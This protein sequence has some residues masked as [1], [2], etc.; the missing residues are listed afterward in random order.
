MAQHG[1]SWK[2]KTLEISYYKLARS[3]MPEAGFLR[4]FKRRGAK[5]KDKTQLNPKATNEMIILILSSA[6]CS[7]K[8]SSRSIT[9]HHYFVSFFSSSSEPISFI[10]FL[11]SL[12][13]LPKALPISGSLVAPKIKRQIKEC[14]WIMQPSNYSGR[15]GRR[16]GSLKASCGTLYRFLGGL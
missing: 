13:V 3:I 16:G 10:D 12:I 8:L 15:I 6:R 11:N 7:T 9:L 14:S 2:F 1:F 4:I 5:G